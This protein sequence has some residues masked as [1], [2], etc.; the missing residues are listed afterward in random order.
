MRRPILPAAMPRLQRAMKKLRTPS[1]SQGHI[2][3]FILIRDAKVARANT[4]DH[5]SALIEKHDEIVA[6]F[7]A[8]NQSVADGTLH[9]LRPSTLRVISGSLRSC[10]ENKTSGLKKLQQH[11]D[12]EQE[13]RF[14][15]YCPMCG[16][17]SPSS[18]DHYLPAVRFPE[19]SVHP[20]N[21][22]PCCGLCNSTKDDDWLN[23]DSQRQY[24][25]LYSDL[26]PADQFLQVSLVPVQGLSS[27]GAV[28]A[29]NRPQGFSHSA[30]ILI[31]T[32]FRRL[33]LLIDMKR[34]Q[35][36]R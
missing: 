33:R 3:H 10:Y 12:G 24:L 5:K 4:F 8:F 6:R 16:I 25:H 19:L 34:L 1:T 9:L 7:A 21:F 26:I 22:V 2:E 15:K 17:T 28:F 35:M 13:V 18:Y 14:L 30:W 27:P 23:Q 31:E 11:I 32:H 36:T 20:L 29:I